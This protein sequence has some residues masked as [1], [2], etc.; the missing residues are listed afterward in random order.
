MSVVRSLTLVLMGAVRTC[1]AASGVCAG[2][3]T[4]CRTTPAQVSFSAP[5]ILTP[6]GS[7]CLTYMS[8]RRINI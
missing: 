6:S 4:N 1:S 8:L 5:L 2:Q 3:D 7:Q